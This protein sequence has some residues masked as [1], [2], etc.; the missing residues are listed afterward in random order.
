MDGTREFIQKYSEEQLKKETLPERVA[1]RFELLACI[2]VSGTHASFLLRRIETG[3]KYLLKRGNAGQMGNLRIEQRQQ[4]RIKEALGQR[5]QERVREAL[6]QRRQANIGEAWG[7]MAAWQ[8]QEETSYWTE[9]GKEYLLRRYIE[10]QN[11][12]EYLE[13]NPLLAKREALDIA[14]KLCDILIKLHHLHPPMIHRDIKPQNIIVDRFGTVHLIDFEASRNFDKNKRK[15]TRFYGTEATAAPEQYGYAQTDARTDIYAF[16][17]VLCYLLTGDYQVEDC[18]QRAGRLGLIVEKCCA[19]DPRKRFQSMEEVKRRLLAGQRKGEPGRKKKMLRAWAGAMALAIVFVAGIFLGNHLPGQSIE[20]I[21]QKEVQR[22][23]A[24]QGKGSGAQ[25]AGQEDTQQDAKEIMQGQAGQGEKDAGQQAGEG[26]LLLQAA[27]A[28][29]NKED[30]AEE[31][32]KDVVRVAVCGTTVYDM[33]KHFEAEDMFHEDEN[34]VANAGQGAITDISLLAKMP[35]LSE[36]YLYNQQIKDIEALEGL[37]IRK[38]YLSGNQIEDFRVVEKLPRLSELC[39]TKNP[40]RYLPDFTKCERLT[41]LI[42]N[43]M[44]VASLDCLKG[45][46]VERMALRRLNVANGDYT[47]LEELPSLHRLD[48]W[49]PSEETVQGIARLSGLEEIQLFDYH[50]ADIDFVSSLE[51]LRTIYIQ[52]S[53]DL[54]LSPLERLPKINSLGISYPAEDISVIRNMQSLK[55]LDIW[56]AEIEDL[57]PILDCKGID[58]LLVNEEQASYLEKHDYSGSLSLAK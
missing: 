10:G 58:Y 47:F 2:H 54:D 19:F 45:A 27:A 4:E 31:D 37:P 29:L 46:A 56:N 23:L 26:D 6:G 52:S 43:E 13:R 22:Q 49:N 53:Y 38:L 57:S 9:G 42:M 51:N 11:L 50:R 24:Q 7:E 12:E 36:V 44:T 21:V 28:S 5:R 32:F 55:S 3:E 8:P 1:G 33:T 48:I 18:R 30:V 25:Q 35:N 20:N 39:I 14:R 16:G 17:K 15:D 40:V 34:Y 41:T